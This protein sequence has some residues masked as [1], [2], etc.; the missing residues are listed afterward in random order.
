MQ[1]PGI[2]SA[3]AGVKR[4]F[5]GLDTNT[6]L[7]DVID[8]LSLKGRYGL[9]GEV[10]EWIYYEFEKD[11]YTY[12]IYFPS[13]YN[14]WRDEIEEDDDF[15]LVPAD[16]DIQKALNERMLNNDV[17]VIMNSAKSVV[18]ETEDLDV[19]EWLDVSW[20]AT[21]AVKQEACEVP[22]G[23][24]WKNVIFLPEGQVYFSRYG[25]NRLM[26]ELQ[27]DASEFENLVLEISYDYNSIQEIP[28]HSGTNY[29]N[30]AINTKDY[31]SFLGISVK[32]NKYNRYQKVKT[33]IRNA[34][35]RNE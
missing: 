34:V 12:Y 11:D 17:F 4:V 3:Y 30:I 33:Y 29:F 5:D 28:L 32:D 15:G 31:G 13:L 10:C 22:S 27:V 26:L 16:A 8:A 24:T 25:R 19:Y 2:Y 6:T 21:A 1:R 23:E 14:E 35:L 9:D 18:S 7:R 20:N